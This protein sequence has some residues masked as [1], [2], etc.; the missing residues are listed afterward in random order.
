[1][2]DASFWVI[3]QEMLDSDPP[4]LILPAGK[5]LNIPPSSE[6]TLSI[7]PAGIEIL[8]GKRNWLVTAIIDRWIGGVHL[9][10]D[11]LWCWNAEADEIKKQMT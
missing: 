8:E 7:T 9:T 4:L 5:K 2:G 1:M 6:Q 10:P 3:L 11:N